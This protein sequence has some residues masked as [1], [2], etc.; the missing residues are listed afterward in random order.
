MSTNST[1]EQAVLD[2]IRSNTED[3]TF[4]EAKYWVGHDAICSSG[5][6]SGLIY[7][8]DTIAFFDRHEEEI[9]DLAKDCDFDVSVVEKG[10]TGMKNDMAWFAFE[11]LKDQVFGNNLELFEDPEPDALNPGPE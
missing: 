3:Y 9:L 6:V 7:Y 1:L 5:S 2:E 8:H 10:I 4:E 11:M